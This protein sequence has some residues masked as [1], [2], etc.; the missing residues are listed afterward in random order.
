MCDANGGTKGK[1][2]TSVGES[3]TLQAW[4]PPEELSNSYEH[5]VQ[6]KT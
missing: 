3:L 6:L 1:D 2:F 5:I 4:S